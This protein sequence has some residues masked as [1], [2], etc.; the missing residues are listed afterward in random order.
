MYFQYDKQKVTCHCS[1][2]LAIIILFSNSVKSFD[3]IL[4][5]LTILNNFQSRDL[6]FIVLTELEMQ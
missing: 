6:N 5:Y 2:K 3:W 1:Y 4:I